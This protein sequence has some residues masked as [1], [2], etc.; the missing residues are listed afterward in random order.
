MTMEP[1][2]NPLWYDY[3]EPDEPIGPVTAMVMACLCF[4]SS[5]YESL[6]AIIAA[7]GAALVRR[8]T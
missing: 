6:R 1:D 4:V 2:D 8:M 5:I 3:A 7:G